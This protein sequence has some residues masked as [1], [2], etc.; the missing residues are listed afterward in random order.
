MNSGSCGQISSSCN[1]PILWEFAFLLMSLLPIKLP[2][3]ISCTVLLLVLIK[4]LEEGITLLIW[5]LLLNNFLQGKIYPVDSYT[6][7]VGSVSVSV[8]CSVWFLFFI[9]GKAQSEPASA[10]SFYNFFWHLFMQ[11]LKWKIYFYIEKIK[12]MST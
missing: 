7:F 10:V 8:T 6:L 4:C 11:I 9:G 1:C 5:G 2:I 3:L 12:Y